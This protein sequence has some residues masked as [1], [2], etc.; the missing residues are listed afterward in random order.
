MIERPRL[1]ERCQLDKTGHTQWKLDKSQQSSGPQISQKA[2]HTC[3]V[4]KEGLERSSCWMVCV[5]GQCGILLVRQA[6]PCKISELH[7]EAGGERVHAYKCNAEGKPEAEQIRVT[8]APLARRIPIRVARAYLLH[9]KNSKDSPDSSP[10]ASASAFLSELYEQPDNIRSCIPSENS[11]KMA[12]A[13]K[14][15]CQNLR[16]RR[17]ES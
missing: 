1:R 3:G 8:S 15:C 4:W 12:N 13:T 2:Q 9:T 5:S 16:S 6:P 7:V 17:S 14:R 10:V 11:A